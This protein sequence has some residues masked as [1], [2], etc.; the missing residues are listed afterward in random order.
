MSII[1]WALCLVYSVHS[2]EWTLQCDVSLQNRKW[3]LL[4]PRISLTGRSHKLPCQLTLVYK[5]NGCFTS[6][7]YLLSAS[8]MQVLEPQQ[9]TKILDNLRARRNF[10]DKNHDMNWEQVYEYIVRSRKV[11]IFCPEA[12]NKAFFRENIRKAG[13]SLVTLCL[14]AGWY[15]Y[16]PS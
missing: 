4:L 16:L 7:K 12:S 15:I 14:Q 10:R 3:H 8:Y 5:T 9:Q 1:Y 6:L 13:R 2:V 11:S